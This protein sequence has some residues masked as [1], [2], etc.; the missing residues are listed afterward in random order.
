MNMIQQEIPSPDGMEALRQSIEQTRIGRD[1]LSETCQRALNTIFTDRL[2][3]AHGLKRCVRRYG[4]NE[5]M[6]IISGNDRVMCFHHFG[7]RRDYLFARGAERERVTA[8]IHELSDAVRQRVLLDNKLADL[9]RTYLR[10]QERVGAREAH[11]EDHEHER[12]KGRMRQ[13]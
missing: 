3:A 10:L 2:K 11:T 8:A 6:R 4:L 5:T 1:L 13:R 7:L 12:N 9:M